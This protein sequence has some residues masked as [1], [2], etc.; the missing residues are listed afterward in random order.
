MWR[1]HNPVEVHCGIGAL[2]QLSGLLG[3]RRAVLITIPEAEALGWTAR[4][5]A[6]LGDRLAGVH[7]CVQPNPD[8]QWLAPMFEDLWARHADTECLIALGGGSAIDCAKA[9]LTPTASGRFDEVLQQ[10][11]AGHGLPRGAHKALI[12]IPTTAGTGSEVT[13]W[14]TVWDS[15]AQQKYSLQLP[16]SWP[17]AALIDATL[18]RSLPAEATRASALD[19]LSHA[20]EAIWNVNRNPVSNALALSAV[21]T[22]MATLPGLLQRLDDIGLRA[23]IA[24]A[25]LQAGLAFSNTKTALAHS[26]SYGIT[27]EHGVA[28][29]IACSFSLGHVARLAIGHDPEVDRLLAEATQTSDASAA[30]SAIDRFLESVGVST[31]AQDHGVADSAWQGLIDKALKGP[32]GLNFIGRPGTA[33]A[34]A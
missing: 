19:A 34:A 24:T 5:R 26:L 30:A 6:G 21:R 17:E 2:D 18:M 3:S 4:I 10:L 29:G 13:P 25:A 33:P 14:A 16:W 22:V 20:L 15:A 11:R 9:M 8:V 1:Y 31:R 28:H 32:R 12:A 7:A 27:L 23:S